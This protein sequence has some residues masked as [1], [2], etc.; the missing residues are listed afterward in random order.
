VAKKGARVF[1]TIAE[2][3]EV[4][5]DSAQRLAREGAVLCDVL[6][7]APGRRVVDLA[8]GTGPH[9][10]FF[11]ER[12]AQVTAYDASAAMVAH[13]AERRPH[14]GVRY[15]QRD[16]REVTGGPWDMALCVGNSLCLLPTLEDIEKTLAETRKSLAPGGLLLIQVLNY[17]HP[18][19]AEP[20]HRVVH[21]TLKDMEVTAVKSLVPH[22]DH[23]LLAL[24]FYA[25]SGGTYTS[26]SET[27]VLLHVTMAGLCQ[28]AQR[29]GFET[30]EIWGGYNR[31]P[32]DRASSSDLLCLFGRPR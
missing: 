4:L 7:R 24:A 17:E 13:A 29:S 26:A 18:S 23:T 11:A 19:M 32:F 5:Y 15:E 12:G 2:Y 31:S 28:I 9:A 6:E 16:M 8:C 20:S 21:K 1:Q 27:A 14:P 22:L 3:Y 30:C 25:S 10:R